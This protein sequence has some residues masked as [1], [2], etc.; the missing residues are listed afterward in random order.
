MEPYSATAPGAPAPPRLAVRSLCFYAFAAPGIAA[1]IAARRLGGAGSVSLLPLVY[2]LVVAT[3]VYF[4]FFFKLASQATYVRASP[5]L[6][7]RRRPPLGADDAIA[8]GVESLIL[9]ALALLVFFSLPGG[10]ITT[11]F[12]IFAAMLLQMAT[13]L[14]A[15]GDARHPER[16]WS[17]DWLAKLVVVV[18]VVVVVFVT[19]VDDFST[20]FARLMH[21]AHRP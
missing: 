14:Q 20:T 1:G 8:A 12:W 11:P 18:A 7:A 5:E 17:A 21:H 16:R 3:Y 19:N 2:A 9:C 6:R 4:W 15:L 10:K 13:A